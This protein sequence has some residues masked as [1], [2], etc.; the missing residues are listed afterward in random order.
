MKSNS[1]HPS[2]VIPWY[3][4]SEFAVL[5]NLRAGTAAQAYRAW[6][7]GADKAI[8]VARSQGRAVQLMPVRLAAFRDW[9]ACERRQDD[10]ASRRAFL[11]ACAASAGRLARQESM[12][13]LASTMGR[14]RLQLH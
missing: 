10:L 5:A 12:K 8:A 4:E 7:R 9:L 6:R 13:S 1:D 11:L 2:T 3:A 14:Q